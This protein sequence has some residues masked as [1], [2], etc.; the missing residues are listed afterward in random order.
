MILAW[1]GHTYQLT[2]QFLY[3]EVLERS[4][5][6]IGGLTEKQKDSLKYILADM[7]VERYLHE[8]K[9]Q[10]GRHESAICSEIIKNSPQT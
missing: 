9:K 2:M 5:M 10:S 3:H 4:T 8:Q 6:I 1:L 7:V